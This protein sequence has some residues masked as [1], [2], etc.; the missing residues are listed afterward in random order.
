MLVA[1]PAVELLK[2]LICPRP[3]K[4]ALFTKF[5][6][7]PELLTIPIPSTFKMRVELTAMVKALAPGLKKIPFTSVF[8]EIETP[9]VFET[10]KIAMLFGLLGTTA[11][12]Q[13]VAV[14]QSLLPGLRFQVG[15]P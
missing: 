12:V 1:S 3:D 10:A 4:S 8:A 2:K 11:G 6:M 14:F 13:L 5:W 15:L 7:V 9:V